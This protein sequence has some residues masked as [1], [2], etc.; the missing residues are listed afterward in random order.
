MR[1]ARCVLGF[2]TFF[3]FAAACAQ[4]YPAKPV[5]L[6]VPFPPYIIGFVQPAR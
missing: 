5:K 2:L 6:I 4:P 1:L 3:S